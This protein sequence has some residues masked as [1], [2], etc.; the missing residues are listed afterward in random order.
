MCWP[1]E[2]FAG[3]CAVSNAFASRGV[4]SE[5]YELKFDTDLNDIMGRAGYAH[6]IA[7]LLQ[8]EPAS[9][10]WLSEVFLR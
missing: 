7:L 3:Q 6:A 2:F 5:A 8:L 9:F 10:V 4:V 1:L